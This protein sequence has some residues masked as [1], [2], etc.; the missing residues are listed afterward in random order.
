[1]ILSCNSCQKKFVVPDNAISAAGRLVQCSSCGNK[2]TQFPINE[3]VKKKASKIKSQP[4]KIQN[5][6]KKSKRKVV[7]KNGPSLYSPEYL[8]KKHGI[9]INSNPV[10]KDKTTVNKTKVSLGFYSFIIVSVVIVIFILR[11]LYFTQNIIIE[12]LP[13]TEMYI[14]YL[15]ESIKNIKELIQNFFSNY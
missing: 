6:T 9:K 2:W 15:F 14:D 7:T 8:A 13:I 3:K 5:S 12:K 11:L 1:M 10:L 4:Q